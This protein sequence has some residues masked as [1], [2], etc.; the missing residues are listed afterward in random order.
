MV[1]P[2]PC[3][4]SD[5]PPTCPPLT[6]LIKHDLDAPVYILS[7]LT[8]PDSCNGHRK[9][10]NALPKPHRSH[11]HS[12]SHTSTVPDRAH[13]LL[14]GLAQSCSLCFDFPT[15][16]CAQPP[17]SRCTVVKIPLTSEP[18]LFCPDRRG[19][20]VVTVKGVSLIHLQWARSKGA[21]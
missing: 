8:R 4:V 20:P 19:E 21:G 17:N 14:L 9:V 15:Q 7:P 1:W 10:S 12:G 16:W 2:C 18:F 11:L 3:P 5:S 13:P 6:L